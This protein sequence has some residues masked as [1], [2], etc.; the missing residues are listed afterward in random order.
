MGCSAAACVR[1]RKSLPQADFKKAFFR[2]LYLLAL[3]LSSVVIF[4][5]SMAGW[6][7]LR[8]WVEEKEQELEEE[9]AEEEEATTRRRRRRRRRRTTTT[10]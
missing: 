1:K 9:E 3:L 5:M 7:S 2:F 6:G 10:T 8:T 4:L